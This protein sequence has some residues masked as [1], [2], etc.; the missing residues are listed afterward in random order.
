[1]NK[2]T[3]QKNKTQK[4]KGGYLS[5]KKQSIKKSPKTLKSKK[6]YRMMSSILPIILNK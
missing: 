1:M 4:R 6:S 5:Q 2:R 3:S